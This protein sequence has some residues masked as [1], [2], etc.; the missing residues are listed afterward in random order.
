M[1]LLDLVEQDH[2]V[3]PAAHRF[4]ELA[5]FVIADV[6][7]RRADETRNAVLLAVLAHVDA[8][9]RALVV[10]EVRRKCFRELRLTDTGGAEEQERSGRTVGI[11]DARTCTSHRVGDGADG[12]VLTD[13]ALGQLVL[14]AEQLRGL[15][16]EQAPGWNTGPGRND[17]CDV[18]RPDFFLDHRGGRFIRGCR[19][20]LR[21]L[22]LCRGNL[23]VLQP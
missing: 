17:F 1:G 10:E 23:C 9:H 16:F 15:P 14:H 5:A 13:Y 6:S 7:R 8:H 3:G 12:L 4:G 11:G 18:V 22:A 20:G 21:Q 2:R 19:G